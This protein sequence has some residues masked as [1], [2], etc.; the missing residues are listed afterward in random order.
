MS[1]STVQPPAN[2]EQSNKQAPKK[3]QPTLDDLISSMKG[4]QDD[5]GQISELSSEEKRV[6]DVFFDSFLKLMKP[7]AKTISISP[8]ALP[9]EY[10]H[11]VQ[12][13][14]D[15]KG[16]F[17]LLFPDGQVEIRN[18]SEKNERDLMIYVMTDALPKFKQLTSGHRR[19]IE[20]RMKFLSSVTQEIQKISKAF[21]AEADE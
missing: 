8:D 17:M 13:N 3:P 7:L 14:V 16:N 21:A 11:V 20:N 4:L 12:A 6:V 18:L 19:T 2:K 1:Q 5:I 10:S 9:E 15:P